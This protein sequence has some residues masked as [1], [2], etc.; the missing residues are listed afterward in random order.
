MIVSTHTLSYFHLRK[1]ANR[2]NFDPKIFMSFGNSH[3]D[4]RWNRGRQ[5]EEAETGA[6]EVAIDPLTIWM[7][8]WK[9]AE[10]QQSRTRE[11][12]ITEHQQSIVPQKQVSL[13]RL[14]TEEE[15]RL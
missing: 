5:V 12:D 1:Q 11:G 7:M 13:P 14:R 10:P 3:D 4:A 6:D 2:S 9:Q 15:R 8:N